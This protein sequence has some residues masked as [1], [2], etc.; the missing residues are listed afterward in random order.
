[1][2]NERCLKNKQEILNLIKQIKYSIDQLANDGILNSEGRKMKWILIRKLLAI[3]ETKIYVQR[4]KKSD[5]EQ[6]FLDAIKEIEH[7]LLEN[8]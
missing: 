8:S 6:S 7:Y 2:A 1:M 5:H 4:L 3:P